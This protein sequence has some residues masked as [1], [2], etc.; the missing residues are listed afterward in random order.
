MVPT[1]WWFYALKMDAV[2]KKKQALLALLLRLKV[3]RFFPSGISTGLFIGTY[4]C[5]LHFLVV[6]CEMLKKKGYG[7][8]GFSNTKVPRNLKRHKHIM[9]A[10]LVY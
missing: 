8:G 1:M 3:P 6:Q 10:C 9:P 7:N 2:L 4:L 5:V